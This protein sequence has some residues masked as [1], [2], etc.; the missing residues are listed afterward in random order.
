MIS[1]M[2]LSAS[3]ETFAANESGWQNV[4]LITGGIEAAGHGIFIDEVTIDGAMK[5]LLGRT[6]RSYLKHDGAGSDR[7]GQEIGFFSGIYRDKL[8]L[9]AKEFRFLESFRAEAPATFAKLVELADKAPDQFGV[10]LVL[11]Y[12]PVWV[13]ADGQEIPAVLGESAPAGAVRSLPSVRIISVNSADLV[14]RPAANPNGLLSAKIDAPN[15]QQMTSETKIA[16]L[17][18]VKA[19]HSAAL[20]AKDTEIASLKA[21]SEAETAKLAESHKVALSEKD[22]LIATLTADKT[23][24]ETSVA[25][26]SKERDALKI[27]IDELVAFDARQLGVAPVKVAAAQLNRKLSG[28]KTPEEKLA[29]YEAMPDGSEKTAFRKLHRD[30]L[31]AAFSARK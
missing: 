14:Q 13:L 27:Q 19:E 1:D 21:A 17:D 5:A 12:K 9:R 6:L 28:Y 25:E 11:E 3:L 10:S 15:I 8:Q 7:L 16:E 31:F 30:A 29:A 4:S 24:A 20:A 26:L 22:A 2:S 18:A 23:K